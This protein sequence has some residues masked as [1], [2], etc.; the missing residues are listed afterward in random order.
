MRQAKNKARFA[1]AWFLLLYFACQ[2]QGLAEFQVNVRTSRGQ[3]EPA[4]AA[5]EDGSF[6]VVFHSY[7]GYRETSN[8]IV[9]RRFDSMGNPLGAEFEINGAQKENQK[10]A[11]IAMRADGKFVVAWESQE[12]NDPNWHVFARRFDADGIAVADRFKVNDDPNGRYAKVA[13]NE[14]GTF[15]I[16]WEQQDMIHP[17]YPKNISFKL[18]EANG[19]LVT[20]GK[21]N[22]VAGCRLPD[23]GMDDAGNFTVV[24]TQEVA[25]QTSDAIFVRQYNADAIAVDPCRVSTVEF[26]LLAEP[27]V[28][29]NSNGHF[30]VTWDAGLSKDTKEIYARRYKFDG[31]AMA[32]EFRVNT[33]SGLQH[34]D[35]R[36]WLNDQGE[37]VIV[38]SRKVSAGCDEWD[39][40]GQRYDDSGGP[41][42]D[43]F[44]VNTY[45]TSNQ[46]HP[47]VA[48]RHDG[49]FVATWQSEG[50]DG[51]D[52]GIFG[53]IGPIVGTADFDSDGFIDF[54][55]YCAL[56]GQWL[57]QANPGREDLVDDN[58]IDAQDL[59]AFADQWLGFVYQCEQ[60]DL[61]TD[62]VVDFKDF[63]KLAKGWRQQGPLDGDITGDG[64]VGTADLM[65][66][67]LHWARGCE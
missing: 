12:P 16:V 34:E 38:W 55:D 44:R 54:C 18:Y 35:P 64:Y 52:D 43:E 50:Q 27:S 60:A 49:T 42:G 19:N 1:T 14:S 13:M 57:H 65:A 46:E 48:L 26:T 45:T 4:A 56:A 5:A 22:L 33:T 36:G 37:S 25:G 67:C 21:V 2:V 53:Q 23:V 7:F 66:L 59:G 3:A 63:S 10:K 62:G 28:S 58:K 31:T 15:V 39:I 20:G 17:P 30:L 32:D 61:E 9:G 24:W 11:A 40:F 41:V 47:D 8:D 29:V 51:A 6:V